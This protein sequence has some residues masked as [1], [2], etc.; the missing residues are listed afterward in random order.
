M[1]FGERSERMDRIIEILAGEW[2]N[3]RV[4]QGTSL[5]ELGSER[6]CSKSSLRLVSVSWPWYV[7]LPWT[8]DGAND[9]SQQS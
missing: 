5:T 3:I 4:L 7:T 8:E 9:I 1:L 6:R 2:T